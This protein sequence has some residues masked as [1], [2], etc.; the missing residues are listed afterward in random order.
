MQNRC[1][2]SRRTKIAMDAQQTLDDF[3]SGKFQRQSSEN[4]ITALRQSLQEPEASDHSSK[5]GDK[6]IKS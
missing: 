5:N 2:E 4:V 6:L 1:Y 3:R